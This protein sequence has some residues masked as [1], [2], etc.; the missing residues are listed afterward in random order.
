MLKQTEKE[1]KKGHVG[2]TYKNKKKKNKNKRQTGKGVE[3]E[4][5]EREK[6]I[7]FSSLYFLLR[8]TKILSSKFVGPR[9]KSALCDEGYAWVQKTQDFAKN[10]GKS[11]ENPNF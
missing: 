3:N 10:S 7:F 9:T 5:S 4:K 11:S 2:P 6:D 1:K 8:F